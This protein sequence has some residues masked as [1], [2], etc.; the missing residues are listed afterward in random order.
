[1]TNRKIDHQYS[2][3]K[4]SYSARKS[5][6]SLT[7]KKVTDATL[8][9]IEQWLNTL[10]EMGRATST[11]RTYLSFVKQLAGISV[12]PPKRTPTVSRILS[13]VEVKS[14][15]GIVKPEE[16]ALIAVLLLCG[17]SVLNWT[18]ADLSDLPLDIPIAAKMIMVNEANRRGFDTRSLLSFMAPAAHWVKGLDQDEIIFPHSAHSL[19]RLLKSLGRKAG[20]GAK[21]MNLTTF[22]YTHNRL[23]FEYRD[24]DHIAKM[25]GLRITTSPSISLPAKRTDTRL[26]GIG[27]R[28]SLMT[29][30]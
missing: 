7:G 5:F 17:T 10:R 8:D 30:I 27:R 16:Y 11:C 23:I 2:T 4:N 1:M 20:I 6:E 3:R 12:T 13:D 26:H 28:S 9:D 18:W 14:M 29:T 22:K 24:A 19:N 15:L 21:H 25:L